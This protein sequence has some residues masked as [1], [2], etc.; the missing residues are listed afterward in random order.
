[1]SLKFFECKNCRDLVGNVD[2]RSSFICPNCGVVNITR[3]CL[4]RAFADLPAKQTHPAEISEK[5]KNVCLVGPE[6]L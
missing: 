4:I 6:E 2:R 3:Y 5:T 1:M